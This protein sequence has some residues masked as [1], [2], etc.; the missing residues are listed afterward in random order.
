M[1]FPEIKLPL[2]KKKKPEKLA[3]L[4]IGTFAIKMIVLKSDEKNNLSITAAGKHPLAKGA[5]VDKDIRDREGIIYAIQTIVDEIAPDITDVVISLAGHK[6]L[7]DRVEI[8][9]PSGKAKHQQQI[10]EAV[11]VEAEQRIP[12]GIDSVRIDYMEIGQSE[13]NK[14]T[15]V[16][17]FAARNEIVDE[18][19]GIVMDAGLVPVVVDL[20][21]IALYN[22]FEYN[23]EIPQ[24]GCIALVNIGHSL[25]NV[26]FIV[27][28]KLFS[29]RDIS[30]AARSV[31]DRLQTELH[32]S[33]D[34]LA[35]LMLGKTLLE[36]SPSIRRAIYSSCEDLNIGL[37]MAFS[38][39]ENVSNGIKV[40]K[41]F[42]SGGAVAI[43]FLVDSLANSLGVPSE[44]INSFS[45]IKFDPEIFG[46][47]PVETAQAIYAIATGL[48]Y[49][50]GILHDTN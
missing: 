40:D 1:K 18:Y 7:I 22:I 34:D 33:S 24:E 41:V 19:V 39:L 37:G 27:D 6:V 15:Q 32:L 29:I 45:K 10:K 38:Y 17:L 50:G 42:L 4:D 47:M 46:D 14:Q 23:H 3:G 36:D 35:Q 16:I 20:D 28:G 31:W 44:L 43:P 49:R 26:S 21:P 11:M 13:D 48:A 2:G 25:S 8:P 30:N 5:I 9:A 12:T